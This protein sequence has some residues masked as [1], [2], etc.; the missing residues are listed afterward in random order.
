MRPSRLE[1]HVKFL[2]LQANFAIIR[3]PVGLPVKLIGSS[4]TL[5]HRTA[6]GGL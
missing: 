4:H 5:L 3:A 1:A 6:S 2:D